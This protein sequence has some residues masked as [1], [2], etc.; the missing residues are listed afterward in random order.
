MAYKQDPSNI[1]GI[2]SL[3]STINPGI[4]FDNIEE[5]VKPRNERR[6]I[7][8]IDDEIKRELKQYNIKDDEISS[9]SS[10]SSHSSSNSKSSRSSR[11]SRSSSDRSSSYHSS[12]TDSRTGSSTSSKS[13]RSHHKHRKNIK[14]MLDSTDNKNNLSNIIGNDEI[15]F[16]LEKDR[17][18]EMRSLKLDQIA[19][20]KEALTEEGVDCSQVPDVTSESD[21]T[22]IETVHRILTIRSDRI[23]Y[24]SFAEEFIIMGVMGLET[25]FDGKNEYFGKYRPDLTGWNTNVLTKLKKVRPETS[26]LV[27]SIMREYQISPWVRILFE[28]V[29][30]AIMH[31]RM[32]S[33]KNDK[34][35][36][37]NEPAFRHA[38]DELNKYD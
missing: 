20:M 25:L 35:N 26:M 33:Q 36:L 7:I 19:A 27:G 24:C 1:K 14:S 34:N 8:N 10:R 38:I 21:D 5:T 29:P 32:Q 4:D 22:L 17:Q 18:N 12:D 13:S 16:S 11:S 15:E 9:K 3:F 28:L 2:G 6:K 37:A 31:M 23:K 30:S